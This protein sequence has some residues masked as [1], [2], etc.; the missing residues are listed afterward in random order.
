MDYAGI[1]TRN[2][3]FAV[4]RPLT[5]AEEDQRLDVSASVG[6]PGGSGLSVFRLSSTCLELVDRWY[7]VKGF[8]VWLSVMG[9]LA[10]VPTSSY[11]FV[12]LIVLGEPF[13]EDERW[14]LWCFWLFIAPK[15]VL[16]M[17]ALSDPIGSHESQGALLPPGRYGR[18]W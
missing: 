5:A 9:A 11:L 17:D 1:D 8:N 13:R 10:F 15:R 2:L 12:N 14:I 18:Q 6:V 16:P 4:N 7:P 3:R